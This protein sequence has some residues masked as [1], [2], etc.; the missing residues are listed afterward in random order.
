MNREPYLK[1]VQ[2]DLMLI[3]T[4]SLDTSQDRMHKNVIFF[5]NSIKQPSLFASQPDRGSVEL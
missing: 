2:S 3:F 4:S 1:L 5:D